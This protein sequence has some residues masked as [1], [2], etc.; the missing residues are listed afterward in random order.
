[1]IKL[2]LI[3]LNLFFSSPKEYFYYIYKAEDC[4]I[5]YNYC[6][7]INNYE[8]AF[9]SK[10]LP[11][12]K[13]VHNALIC[14]I[15]CNDTTKIKLFCSYLSNFNINKEYL[16]TPFFKASLKNELILDYLDE[17]LNRSKAKSNELDI[18]LDS[19][20]QVDQ[21]IR[22]QCKQ[23]ATDYYSVC[24]DTI[25]YVDSLNLVKLVAEIDKFGFPK[26]SE[27]S[28]HFPGK[29]PEFLWV[30]CHNK[31]QI[32]QIVTPL[33]EDA[34]SNFSLHPQ[35]LS[36]IWGVNED[37]YQYQEF[38]LG[39][40]VQL[41][42]Q[43]YVFDLTNLTIKDKINLNREKYMLDDLDSY[44]KKIKFQYFNTEFVLIYPV[45][46]PTILAD[47]ETTEMLAEKWK[48]AKVTEYNIK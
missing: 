10:E 3:V 1:M 2:I 7:A 28:G 24:K 40:S 47:V 15:K 36:F 19:I 46:F 9:A 33:L 8:T 48:D 42:G 26:E 18:V 35:L 27:L 23:I 22:E 29:M 37:Y 32:S 16:E 13:D 41:D 45:L 11:F 4:I 38:G 25:L 44:N 5:T 14:S 34:V 31:T 30:I 20:Y 43:L 12:L 39:Y 17:A 21:A 6:D